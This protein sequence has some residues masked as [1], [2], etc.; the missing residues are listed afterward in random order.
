M[1]KEIRKQLIDQPLHI[2]MTFASVWIIAGPTSL[3][4]GHIEYWNGF[5]AYVAGMLTF[6]WAL[7]REVCQWPSS[8]WWDPPLDAAFQWLGL[9][10]GVWSFLSW[11]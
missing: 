3:A 10:L 2:L 8:R 11:M 4:F 9:W 6:A 1:N 5:A 7:A